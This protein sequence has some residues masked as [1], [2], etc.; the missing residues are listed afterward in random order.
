MAD[1]PVAYFEIPVTDLDRAMKFYTQVFGFSLERDTVDGIE[2]A[3]LP[4]DPQAPGATGAL[5]KGEIYVPTR[6]G[7]VI[8]FSTADIDATLARVTA[9]GRPVL[10]PKTD[11]GYA[12]V[13]EFEDSEG[14]RIALLQRKPR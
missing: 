14:N 6:N 12:F 2:L 4:Y 8:Y 9:L 1:N 10:Y 5:A 7:A 11:T 3:W 13:A